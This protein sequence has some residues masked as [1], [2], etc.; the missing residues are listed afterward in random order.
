M[1]DNEIPDLVITDWM[2]PHMTGPEL[3]AVMNARPELAHVPVVL[4]T[5]KMDQ[6]SRNI[7]IG[8]GAVGFLGKPFDEQE[9]RS[10]VTNLLALRRAQL[11][12]ASIATAA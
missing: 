10:L 4:L 3:I 5:A 6:E 7:A 8:Q 2:M 11:R 9:L 12:L 1:I